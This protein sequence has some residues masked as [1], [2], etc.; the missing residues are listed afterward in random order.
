MHHAA[1]AED[2]KQSPSETGRD[3]SGYL[4]ATDA[5]KEVREAY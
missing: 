2:Q 5:Y 1:L 4:K 3:P